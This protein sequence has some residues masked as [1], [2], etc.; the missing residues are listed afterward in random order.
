M[1]E[2]PARPVTGW[3]ALV[4]LRADQLPASELGV[5]PGNFELLRLG[6]PLGEI[7]YVLFSVDAQTEREDW[8]TIPELQ[9][10]YR[11]LVERV[12]ANKMN[13]AKDAVM[14]IARIASVCPE[15]L[16]SNASD[17]IKQVQQDYQN[18]FGGGPTSGGAAIAVP[19]GSRPRFPMDLAAVGVRFTKPE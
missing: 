2:S 5:R 9:T 1:E 18:A 10:A 8:A 13:E 14:A 3:F 19:R 7:P 16:R 12:V 15:L 4:R 6:K 17:I 11:L